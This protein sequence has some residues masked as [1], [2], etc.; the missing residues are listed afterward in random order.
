MKLLSRLLST[1]GLRARAPLAVFGVALACGPALAEAVTVTDVADRTITVEAPIE[2]FILGEGRLIYA[3]A[4]LE[5]SD[6]FQR[7]VG[8]RDDLLK[9]DPATYRVYRESYPRIDDLPTF[10]GIK[11]GTFDIEQA[12]SLDPDVVI[13]NVEARQA[14]EDAGLD[15]KLAAVG[16]PL[17]YSPTS[18]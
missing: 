17:V 8:W 1:P 2:K 4:A 5:E 7:V 16:I 11:D 10:G 13:M 18:S 6:P 3:V 9:A 12:I 14:T 15:D